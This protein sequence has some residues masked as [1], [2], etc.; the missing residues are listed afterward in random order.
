MTPGADTHVCGTNGRA[1][2]EATRIG[3][4]EAAHVWYGTLL[5]RTPSRLVEVPTVLADHELP[6]RIYADASLRLERDFV[7]LCQSVF[8]EVVRM[9]HG[10]I[11]TRNACKNAF[12]DFVRA[13]AAL[14]GQVDLHVIHRLHPV[15]VRSF[16]PVFY[17]LSYR[18]GLA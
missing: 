10:T 15:V 8:L 18:K 5:S 14:L 7:V 9:V 11:A 17:V 2:L 12:P 3:A 1:K 4:C 6:L 13:S 16:G